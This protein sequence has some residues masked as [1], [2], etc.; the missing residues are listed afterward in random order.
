MRLSY[1]SISTYETCPAKYRFQYISK[2]PPPPPPPRGVGGR[3]SA[4]FAFDRRALSPAPLPSPAM[5]A[6]PSAPCTLSPFREAYL[7]GHGA[8]G[9]PL[10]GIE[11]GNTT[12]QSHLPKN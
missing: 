6:R 3:G 11:K 7:N 5:K 9:G 8:P 2:L 12:F 1:S 10:K 4:R